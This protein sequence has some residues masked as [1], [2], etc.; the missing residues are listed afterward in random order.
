MQETAK[1]VS[2]VRVLLVDDDPDFSRIFQ[3]SLR[4]EKLE[5]ALK[6]LR[7]KHF[8]PTLLDPGLH[9]IPEQHSIL[10]GMETDRFFPSSGENY[11]VV[12]DDI[13]RFEQKVRPVEEE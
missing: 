11:S 9:E 8:Q 12:R 13:A 2:P 7:K 6:V 3:I 10:A 4:A 5:S 1:Q